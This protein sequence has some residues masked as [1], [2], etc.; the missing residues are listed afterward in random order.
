MTFIKERTQEEQSDILTRYL[1]NDPLWHDKNVEGSVLKKILIGLAAE[2][3]NLRNIVNELYDNYDPRNTTSL[4]EEWERFVGI[5]D[6]CFSNVGSL[7]QR[8][9]NILLKLAGSNVS[10]A[11]QFE[12][13]AA[14]LGYDATVTNGV[15][16]AT[17][18]ATFPVLLVSAAAAPFTIV[19]NLD[20]SIK[21][22][23]FP[24]SFPVALSSGIPELLNCFFNK[25]KP[26]NT[27]VI[28]RYV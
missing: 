22:A 1:P 28:F 17:L 8:R 21:P 16:V 7:E 9:K 10:T 15:D 11:K 13:V 25:L 14:I 2:W 27:Q 23:T 19:V 24:L 18:P 12:N 5:P 3:L 6:S 4:I 26:A 20:A